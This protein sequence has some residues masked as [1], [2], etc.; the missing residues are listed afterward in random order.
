M[1][2]D[3]HDQK[4]H[5]HYILPDRLI[6][7][8][9][10]ALMILT[11]ITVWVAG[12]DLGKL[13]F[14]VAMV[15]AT[16]KGSLVALIFMNLRKD[17]RENG[18]IFATS[19]LFLAIFIVLT[20]SDL[21][22]RGDVYVK[23]PLVPTSVA[24]SKLK[25][26]WLPTESLVNHGKELFAVQCV[27]CHG[28]HGKGDGMAAAALNPHPRNFTVPEGWKNG[29]KPSMVFKTLKEGLA[30]SAMASFST[31]PSDDRWALAHFVLSMG[32]KPLADTSADLA[33]IGVD[34]SQEGGGEVEEKVLPIETAIDLM[35]VPDQQPT[36]R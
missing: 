9:G 29:R 32:P 2:N 26:P 6:L 30:G 23:G 27:S 5:H 36:V 24:K 10:G 17:K 14:L 13:N 16:I 35:T 19:F 28:D 7:T 15:V 33:S 4:K 3:N 31:L 8:V 34:P 1:A 25:N 18:V 22:F 12:I 21:F 20:S 11:V